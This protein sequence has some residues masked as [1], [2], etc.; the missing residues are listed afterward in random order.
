VVLLDE[1]EKAHP[2][3][4]GLLLQVMDEGRLTDS[5][6]RTVSFRNSVVIMT[7]NLGTREIK[8]I[9][10]IGFGSDA[11]TG[12]Y[13]AMRDK[14]MAEVK[15]LFNPEFMN[16]LD[17]TVVFHAL[18]R[19]DL[20]KIVMLQLKKIKLRLA[21]QAIAVEFTDRIMEKIIRDGY[22]PKF[23][24]RPIQRAIQRLI[25]DPLA[26]ELLKGNVKEGDLVEVDYSDDQ[27]TF[28]QSRLPSAV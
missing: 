7:S 28:T 21:E 22:E 20:R 12:E 11:F 9:S 5:L 14:V 1:I 27:T 25:E 24:A 4:F 17:E 6:G 16:R 15:H 13:F 2:D 23:G 10:A 18:S 8:D 3:V 19:D 26:E